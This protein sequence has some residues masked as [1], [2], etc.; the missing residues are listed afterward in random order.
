MTTPLSLRN[1]EMEYEDKTSIEKTITEYDHILSEIESIVLT[2]KSELTVFSSNRIFCSIQNKDN[3]MN[4]FQSLLER[5]TSI[6]MLTDDVDEYLIK[7]IA[8]INKSNQAKPIQLG[9]TNKLRHLDEIVIIS[10]NKYLL[11]IRYG[12]DNKLVATFSNEEHNVLVQELMFEK[13]WNEV[14]SL[15]VV[16][17]N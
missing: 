12:Q 11:H 2:C 5:G 13:Q 14:K 1:K 8:M 3:F 9:Y 10:D 15:D 17:S 16:N 7:Q 6:K 4:N